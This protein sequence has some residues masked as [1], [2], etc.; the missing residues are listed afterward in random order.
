MY[1]L[2]RTEYVRRAKE[3]DDAE[4]AMVAKIK[5]R[6]RFRAEISTRR[7]LES[8]ED[9][10][11][12]LQGL[13]GEHMAELYGDFELRQFGPGQ[14]LFN[15][16]DTATGFHIIVDGSA[17]TEGSEQAE[18]RAYNIVGRECAKKE[19]PVLFRTAVSAG[20]NGCSTMYLGVRRLWEAAKSSSRESE[21]LERRRSTRKRV[22]R[23][24]SA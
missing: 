1:F 20:T 10:A 15:C 4:E 11:N 3:I 21:K 22:V 14:R 5:S 9:I 18:L 7:I 16:G 8:A 19:E 2:I 12:H 13:D 23:Q 17:V 6:S 24:R